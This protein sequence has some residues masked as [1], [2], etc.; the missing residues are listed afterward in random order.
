VERMFVQH[1]DPAAALAQAQKEADQ[2]IA[3]YNERVGK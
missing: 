3:S 1:Q 2:A